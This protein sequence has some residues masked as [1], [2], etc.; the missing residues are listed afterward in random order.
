MG[1]PRLRRVRVLSGAAR[2]M[3]M[4]LDLRRERA[5]WFGSYE[6]RTQDAIAAYLAPGAVF[7]D[8]GAHVGFF[9]LCAIRAGARVHAFEP[10]PANAARLR[11][12]AE[13]NDANVEVVEA[14]VWDGVTPVRL[15]R[16]SSA[17]EWRIAEPRDGGWRASTPEGT[18]RTDDLADEVA[19]TT[20][21]AYV[22]AHEPP[23]LLKIDAEGAETEILRGASAVLRDHGPALIC[24]VHTIRDPVEKLEPLLPLGYRATR[25]A[26]DRVLAVPT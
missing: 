17:S 7:F 16:R 19:A 8:I 1:S 22:A 9:T 24:E 14:A 3:R 15:V 10:A 26:G 25:L 23:A 18:A 6:R 12:N 13:L 5:Y 11:R 2:G 20:L 4:E 21:D